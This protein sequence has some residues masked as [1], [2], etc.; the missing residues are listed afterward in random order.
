MGGW[1]WIS[2]WLRSRAEVRVLLSELRLALFQF[3]PRSIVGNIQALLS[4]YL[5]VGAEG[6]AG[7]EGCHQTSKMESDS[8][9][10]IPS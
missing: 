6:V 9:L 7:L 3:P 1:L 2:L 8:L 5:V 4:T 10:Q